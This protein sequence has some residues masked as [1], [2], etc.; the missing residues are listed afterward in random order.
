MIAPLFQGSLSENGI[1]VNLK[2][3]KRLSAGLIRPIRKQ[4]GRLSPARSID[5][6]S[7]LLQ[8]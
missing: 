8:P 7:S 2:E 3:M 5:H 6:R 4:T 1:G